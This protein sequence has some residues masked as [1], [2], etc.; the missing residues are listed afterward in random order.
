[1]NDPTGAPRPSHDPSERRFRGHRPRNHPPATVA[2]DGN[3]H[4]RPEVCDIGPDNPYI[5]P[6]DAYIAPES[7]CIRPEIAYTRPPDHYIGAADSYS[8]SDTR[9]IRPDDPCDGTSTPCNGPADACG[10]A[11][12]SYGGAADPCSGEKISCDGV[13]TLQVEE[14]GLFSHILAVL[15]VLPAPAHIII[16]AASVPPPLQTANCHL[17]ILV[18]CFK[19]P[20]G[21]VPT[22][23]LS[24]TIVSTARTPSNINPSTHL[25]A[26]S[27][28]I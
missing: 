21:D 15:P 8:G 26:G 6:K 14:N 20:L 24:D 9:C 16:R 22:Q 17:P 10:G 18:S 27:T 23:Q 5:R 19:G 1:M 28:D 13:E 25:R 11:A 4:S 7:I 12:E 3:R 2:T